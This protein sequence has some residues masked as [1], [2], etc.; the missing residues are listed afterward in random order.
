[1][2]N[3]F[4]VF[5]ERQ[6][7]KELNSMILEYTYEIPLDEARE[8]VKTIL[9][10]STQEYLDWLDA[11]FRSIPFS[12]KDAPQFSKLDDAII[13]IIEKMI[14]AGDTGFTHVELGKMLQDDGKERSVVTDTKYGENHAKTA[15]YLGYVFARNRRYYVSAVGYAARELSEEQRKRLYNRLF[16]RTYLFRQ[17]Y[18]LS[19]SGQVDIRAKMFDTLAPSTYTRRQSNMKKMFYRLLDTNDYDWEPFLELLKF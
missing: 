17:A 16:I 14:E 12:E 1:M 8:Y 7:D 2:N 18:F 19:R 5:F 6:R 11:K 4:D 9:D 3:F 13:N 15:K 10:Y